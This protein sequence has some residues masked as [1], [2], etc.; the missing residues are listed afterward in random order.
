MNSIS[1]VQKVLAAVAVLMI[2]ATGMAFAA[3]SP[4]TEAVLD[5]TMHKSADG[6]GYVLRVESAKAKD[7]TELPDLK[8]KEV[9]MPAD[10]SEDMG[11]AC[12]AHCEK[13]VQIKCCIED[14]K[15]AATSSV[16]ARE[17]AA[18]GAKGKS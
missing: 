10:M 3:P 12:A 7:G 15:I 16:S 18:P 4:H 6:K 1:S 8:G 9:A 5:G 17:V 13:A 14:G 11:A 2:M